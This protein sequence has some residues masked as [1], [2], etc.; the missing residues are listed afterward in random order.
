MLSMMEAIKGFHVGYR[1]KNL[2]LEK[3]YLNLLPEWAG[4]RRD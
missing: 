1:L 4:A 2:S 3:I